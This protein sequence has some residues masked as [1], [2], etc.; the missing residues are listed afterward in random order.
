MVE[1]METELKEVE[2]AIINA[3]PQALNRYKNLYETH[4]GEQFRPNEE[5]VRCENPLQPSFISIQI[6]YIRSNT[7]WCVGI[8]ARGRKATRCNARELD[9]PSI[10]NIFG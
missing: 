1:K 3:D 7:R 4:G 2:Q 10:Y 6:F 5:R 8:I 9:L